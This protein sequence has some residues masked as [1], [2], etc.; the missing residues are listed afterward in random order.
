M[1]P[2]FMNC[3]VLDKF[4]QPLPALAVPCEMEH[5]KTSLSGLGGV[6]DTARALL[7]SLSLPEGYL[8]L[9]PSPASCFLCL[10][11]SDSSLL[12]LKVLGCGR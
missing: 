5:P 9:V 7:P 2:Y 4:T 12:G 1:V 3:V 6:T 10:S 8:Y 11:L